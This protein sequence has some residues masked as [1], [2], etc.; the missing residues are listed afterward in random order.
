MDND[1]DRDTDAGHVGDGDLDLD[2]GAER[3][4]DASVRAL[5]PRSSRRGSWESEASGWSARVGGSAGGAAS[6]LMGLRPGTPS[7]LRDRSLWT[8]TSVRTGGWLNDQADGAAIGVD[9][10]AKEEEGAGESD[11]SSSEAKSEEG[12]H[13]GEPSPISSS[14][15]PPNAVAT[16]DKADAPRES[17]DTPAT[18]P[19][20]DA[21][22]K[23]IDA[24]PT[25]IDM[26]PTPAQRDS[27]DG[28]SVAGTDGMTDVWHSAPSTPMY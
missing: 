26:P 6:S 17:T 3:E 23:K 16:E 7:A 20:A 1:G 13:E 24:T 19:S 15:H 10:Q 28:R 22:Q 12:T 21:K 2:G 9:P 4:V 8:G 11:G 25:H 27:E 14:G 5:R 18:Y